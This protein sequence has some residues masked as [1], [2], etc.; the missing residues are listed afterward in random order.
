MHAVVSDSPTITDH[1]STG[2]SPRR[3]T[4]PAG[5]GGFAAIAMDTDLHTVRCSRTD[6]S[7]GA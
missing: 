3:A 2:L 6:G 5:P 4:E 7:K 1:L